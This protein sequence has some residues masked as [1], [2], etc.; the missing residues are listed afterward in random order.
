MILKSC[1]VVLVCLG[2]NG[3]LDAEELS[4]LLSNGS[5]EDGTYSPT[6][7]PEDWERN[8]WL[9]TATFAWDENEARTCARSIKIESLDPNDA[10]WSQ[11]ADVEPNTVYSLSGWIKTDSVEHPPGSVG[12]GANLSLVDTWTHS[13]GLFGTQT[14]TRSNI[15]FNSGDQLQVTV[16]GRLGYW[17]GTTTGSAWFDDLRLE[18][19]LPMDPHP[20]WEILVLIYQATDFQVTDEQGIDHHYVAAMTDDERE[21]AALAARM[22]AETDIPTLTSGNMMPEVT[23]RTPDHALDKLSAIGDGWWPSP[24]DIAAD[25]DPDFDSVIVIW[26]TRAVDITTGES[27]WIGWMDGLAAHRGTNQTYVSMQID[28]AINRGNRNVFKH[29][30][31]HSILNFFETVGTSPQPTVNNHA[32]AQQYV[33]CETGQFYVWEDESLDNPIPNSVYNNESGFTHDYYSGKTATAGE[34]SRC[35]G[36]SP[37]AWAL[38][39]PVSHSGNRELVLPPRFTSD[40]VT[41]ATQD[42]P[43][44]YAVTADDPECEELAIIAPQIP[45]WLELVD[46]GDGTAGVSGTPG[47]TDVGANAVR[48]VATD[49]SGLTVDQAFTINVA[50]VNDAPVFTSTAV[51]AATEAAAYSYTA[52]AAD[53]D[54]DGLWITAPT[55]PGWLTLSDNNDGTATLT[56]TPSGA[57][58]GTYAIELEARE[59]AP[60]AGLAA[61]QSFVISVTAAPEGPIITLIGNATVTI[62]QGDAYNDAGATASDLQDGDLTARI[63]TDNPVDSNVATTYTVT[64]SVADSAGNEAQAQRT[65]IV[66]AVA[67]I[68]PPVQGNGDG[69]A[70]FIATAAYGSYLDPHVE[71]LRTF[72]DRW[73]MTNDQGRALVAFYYERSPPIADA[74]KKYPLLRAIVRALLMPIVYGLTIPNPALA[75]MA[76]IYLLLFR[77]RGTLWAD[78]C[79]V[80][81]ECRTTPP[82]RLWRSI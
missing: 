69:G 39:G 67:P 15:L 57:D 35:L 65:V 37:E 28:A 26:D 41:V 9:P 79:P 64:Y 18:Q 34:P 62:T 14:W 7:A 48:L 56:G 38:G 61:R 6:A 52:T 70:C 23:I 2:A 53:P 4:N 43:F 20:G 19:V 71:V 51:T 22:F 31:G 55:L 10:Y 27:K 77:L 80:A 11:T 74:I 16:G 73:L 54:A 81:R 72:R 17:S 75:L 42:T 50:N 60:A 29:E 32:D 46:N 25:R 36:I 78:S 40:P 1:A 3:P 24:E 44:A 8:A 66:E 13:A 47:N 59:T 30:F 82:T 76:T 21:R 63:D 5:F 12:A 58:I 45:D 33:N 49:S 68:P